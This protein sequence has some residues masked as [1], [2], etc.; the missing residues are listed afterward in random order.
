MGVGLSSTASTPQ[1]AQPI[2]D[3]SDPAWKH[4]SMPDVKK[5][6]SLKCN[7][8]LNTYTGGITRIKYHLA[9]V[10]KSGV[11]KC[12]KVPKDVLN[13]MLKLLSN[14]INAKNSKARDREINR[15]QVDLSQRERRKVM[16]V[17]MMLL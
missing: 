17:A 9:K 10:P 2:V 14:K 5:K 1:I 12:K 8:C 7:Y 4:C 15:A 13:E 16:M 6:N 11:A 3:S